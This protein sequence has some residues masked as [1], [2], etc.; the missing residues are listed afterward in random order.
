MFQKKGKHI[1]WI[2]QIPQNKRQLCMTNTFENSGTGYKA[3]TKIK[4]RRTCCTSSIYFCAVT[5]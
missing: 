3:R 5:P 2:N 1:R 4:R